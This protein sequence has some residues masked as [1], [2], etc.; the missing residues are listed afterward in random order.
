MALTVGF[1]LFQS[2][3]SC[4]REETLD[5]QDFLFLFNVFLPPLPKIWTRQ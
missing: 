2:E 3:K 5:P 1:L 4:G